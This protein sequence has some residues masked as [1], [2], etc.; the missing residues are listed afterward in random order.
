MKCEFIIEHCAAFRRTET[1]Y[2][3]V[4]RVRSPGQCDHNNHA[5]GLTVTTW[6]RFLNKL[7]YLV[8]AKRIDRDL[9]RFPDPDIEKNKAGHYDAA[10]E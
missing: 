7:R 9:G 1:A 10:H 3:R 8:G 5:G 6:N 4:R 2:C